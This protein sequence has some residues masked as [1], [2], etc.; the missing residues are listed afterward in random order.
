MK[1]LVLAPFRSA[2][3]D[4]LGQVMDAVTYQCW[5]DTKKLLSSAEFITCIQEQGA[6]ILIV[7]A[8]FLQRE[9]FEKAPDLKLVAVCRA[10]ANLI[11]VAAATQ[12]GVPI[13]NTPARNAI[14]VAELTIGLILSLLRRIPASDTMVNPA[15]GPTP[16]PP[17]S[18]CGAG[19]Y[20]TGPPASSACRRAAECLP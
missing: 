17:T 15:S 18:T 8:D 11:D 5:M 7:E 2:G 16:W 9:V 13:I 20:R 1:A 12:H 4:R 19:S 10:D 3:L 14:A 6:Q